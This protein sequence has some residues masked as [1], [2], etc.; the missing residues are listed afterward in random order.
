MS[1]KEENLS[2]MEKWSKYIKESGDKEREISN[3]LSPG[4][5]N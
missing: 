4:K 2:S 1:N 5:V 3:K